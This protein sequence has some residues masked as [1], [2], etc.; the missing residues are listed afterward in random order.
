MWCCVIAR[1]KLVLTGDE[2]VR[3]V[4]SLYQRLEVFSSFKYELYTEFSVGL[5]EMTDT[6]LGLSREFEYSL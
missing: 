6:G 2:L 5:N 4:S 1:P 3:M